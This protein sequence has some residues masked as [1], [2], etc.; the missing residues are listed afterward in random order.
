MLRVVRAPDVA[1][2]GEVLMTGAPPGATLVAELQDRE[3]QNC[4][5]EEG[6]REPESSRLRVSGCDQLVMWCPNNT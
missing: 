6:W 3:S 1:G 4:E 5:D 2:P